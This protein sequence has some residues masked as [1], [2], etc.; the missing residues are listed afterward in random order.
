VAAQSDHASQ[1][2]FRPTWGWP[3]G[4]PVI[5]R[6]ALP[7]DALVRGEMYRVVVGMYDWREPANRLPGA[8]PDG[9]QVDTLT[10]LT[11]EW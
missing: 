10:L 8:L 7:L 1:N 5:D 11:F 4:E 2:I 3:E 6:A 9:E